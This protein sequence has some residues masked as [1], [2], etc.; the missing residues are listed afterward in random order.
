MSAVRSDTVDRRIS[1]AHLGATYRSVLVAPTAGFES[2]RRVVERRTRMGESPAE[3]YAPYV[4][5]AAGGAAAAILYLKLS[6]LVGTREFPAADL[7]WMFVVAAGVMG[8]LLAL[9]GQSLW[10]IVAVRV[11]RT[12][13]YS[14]GHLRLVWGAAAF[15][16]LFILLLLPADILVA[17]AETFTASRPDDTVSAAWAASSVALGTAAAVWS[18]GL[19]AKGLSVVTEASAGKVAALVAGAVLSVALFIAAFRTIAVLLVGMTG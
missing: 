2:A 11:L 10:S 13:V 17:G 15:P 18:L 6:A 4:L 3:G 16:S 9:A 8:S 14:G 1:S 12:D 19:F 5:A 7:R